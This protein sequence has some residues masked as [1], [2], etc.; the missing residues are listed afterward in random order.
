[1]P[2]NPS[3]LLPLIFSGA[4]KLVGAVEMICVMV[5]SFVT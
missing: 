4:L 2:L 5:M 1:M 3:A